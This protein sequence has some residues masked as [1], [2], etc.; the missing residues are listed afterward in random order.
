VNGRNDQRLQSAA[1]GL[2]LAA[3]ALYLL[4][5]PQG[6]LAL[7]IPYD[8][9]YG[10]PLAKLHPASWLVCLAYAMALSSLG[11]PFAV[12]AQQ[13]RRHSLLAAYLVCT[14]VLMGYALARYGIGGAA[15]LIDTHLMAALSCLTLLLLPV[16][17]HR[18]L[19]WVLALVL[20]A[21]AT[22]GIAEAGL[23]QRFIPLRLGGEDEVPE[24][25]FRASSFM[26][27]PLANA[28]VTATTMPI[29]LLLPLAVGVRTTLWVWLCLSLLAFGGRTSF[30]LAMLFYGAYFV[31]N[32]FRALVH[33]RMNY[34]Q[35]TGGAIGAMVGLTAVV[36]VVAAT[37]LGERIFKSLEYDNSASVRVR[38][39]SV[40]EYMNDAQHWFGAHG[41]EIE[42]L[43]QRMGLQPKFEAIE[44]F[45]LLIYVQYGAVGFVIFTVGFLCLLAY[46]WR[47]SFGALRVAVPL[48]VLIA[49]TS[50]S[51]AAKTAAPLIPFML[52][53]TAAAHLKPR[54]APRQRPILAPTRAFSHA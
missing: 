19:L 45:W 23:Q 7:G 4:L 29:L 25:F 42:H 21:N 2:L 44:N 22:L 27:H 46:L 28:Q 51:L 26:G 1:A 32:A 34:L 12:A 47:S 50:N 5:S 49:S 15:F 53:V 18:R 20:L 41:D 14:L 31:A 30:M 37:G 24:E 6:L 13:L 9:P 3:A 11:H 39:W 36:G 16:R 54:P 8:A 17:Q 52:A 40:L 38:I 33:G 43:Y 48:M 10:S 35:I